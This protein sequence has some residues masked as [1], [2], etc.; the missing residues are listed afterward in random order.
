MQI[1]GY[2]Y[3]KHPVLS[4]KDVVEALDFYSNRSGFKIAFADDAKNP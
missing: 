3:Q 1:K 2:V 4:V